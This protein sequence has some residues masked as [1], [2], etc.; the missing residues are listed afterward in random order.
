M[1]TPSDLS[2]ATTHDLWVEARNF[3]INL[4]RPTP[5]SIEI[6]V[7]RPAHLS[8]VDG[9]VV[10]LSTSPI[11]ATNYPADG[12][13]YQAS[14]D[15]ATPASLIPNPGGARVVGV[16]HGILNNPMPQGITVVA[17]A[18][19]S[20]TGYETPFV[21]SLI[22]VE[23]TSPST[24]YYASVHAS[25]NVLQFY[26][27]GVSS[28]P[29]DG[30]DQGAL[31][32][33]YA[34]S[35]PSLPTA[36]LDPTPGMV[37][38]D[39]QLNII[40]YYDGTQDAWIPTRSD[41]IV[42]GPYNPGVTGQVYL[43]TGGSAL[44][45]FD[46][47]KWVKATNQNLQV[48]V[49]ITTNATGWVPLG[50]VSSNIRLPDAPAPGDFVYDYTLQRIQYWD[51]VVWIYPSA[52]NVLFDAGPLDGVKPAFVL[53][54]T[55][56]AVELADP[57][58]GQLF[59]NTS[60]RQLN[61]WTG[62]T[63]K[64]ANT[65]QQGSTTAEKINIGSDGSYDERVKLM[66]ILQSQLGYPQFCVELTEE[67]FNIAIDN[68]LDT[69]RQL[70]GGAYKNAYIIFTLKANQ[71][72]YFLNSPVDKTDHIVGI[73]HVHRMNVL[74]AGI[75]SDN[76]FM[77]HFLTDY[78][79]SSGHADILSTALLAGLSEE[80]ERIFAGNL[81]FLWDEP[82][83]E[84]TFTRKISRD[85]KVIIDAMMERPEQEL[86]VDRWCR[87]FIQNWAL[88]EL[89]MN[90]GMIR[91]KF[92]SGTPGAGGSI[93]LNGE[94]LIS[95]ARQDMAELKQGLLDY[96]YGGHIGQGNVSFLIG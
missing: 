94:L 36:P 96:E 84:L 34:G 80:F 65:D 76:I 54:M 87:Q 20:T 61:A 10:L 6:Q 66:K 18:T 71:Q 73:S 45:V 33:T 62:T 88:A 1:L 13:Q 40:Q 90:L 64:V 27:I 11:N 46:G 58:I 24:V 17:N 82:T 42:S 25:S 81:T 55:V 92:S 9:Y 3:K 57:Y 38:H 28:Y 60:T 37:Y 72:K 19:E 69:Y 41:T 2:A 32:S 22:T 39:I 43:W 15:W 35:I 12:E 63:W 29:L 21:S 68:A 75:G 79:Y 50:K 95:E 48:R 26:P 77:Q 30:A 85:E 91:S 51:G 8:V 49:P 89:K 83:R 53:P 56:E 23:N 31:A 44:M 14:T 78:Y 16:F 4:T 7:I 70:S 47:R 5:T 67:Q 52:S 86:L 59:Y 93:T 74:G